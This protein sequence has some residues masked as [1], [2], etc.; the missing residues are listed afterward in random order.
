[1]HGSQSDGGSGA[2]RPRSRRGGAIAIEWNWIPSPPPPLRQSEVGS[3]VVWGGRLAC[4]G[5][6]GGKKIP[7]EMKMEWF[8]PHQDS[9]AIF[10]LTK[11]TASLTRC[12]PKKTDQLSMLGVTEWGVEQATSYEAIWPIYPR[13]CST[14][15]LYRFSKLYLRYHSDTYDSYCI[16]KSISL[17]VYIW[18]NFM[19][20]RNVASFVA[21]EGTKKIAWSMAKMVLHRN[22]VETSQLSV[23]CLCC[24]HTDAR[25]RSGG[26]FLFC[27]PRK[28]NQSA[29]NYLFIKEYRKCFL[30]SNFCHS[31]VSVYRVM[32][33]YWQ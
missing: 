23:W 10:Y 29:L 24:V 32:L 13:S 20:K 1:V 31:F 25:G 11:K 16:Y 7:E 22:R 27:L 19:C 21:C 5:D 9:F 18:S 3:G 12:K 2:M 17:F 33:Q 15:K 4:N 26:R 8:L 28:L 6:Y 14:K 30:S